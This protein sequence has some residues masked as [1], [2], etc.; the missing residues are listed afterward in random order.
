MINSQEIIERSVY[1]AILRVAVALGYSLDPNEYLPVSEANSVKL[2]EDIAKLSKYIPIFGTANSSS[3][4]QKTTPRI[5]V[6]ARGFYPGSIGLPKELI[7]K[8]EGVGFSSNEEPYETLDQYIDVHLV[9]NNQEDLRL[10]HQILF[11]SLPQ[12]GYIKPYNEENFLPSG[13]IFIEVG[14]FF[15]YPNTTL[16]LLEKVYEYKVYDTLIGEKED[17]PNDLVP[18]SSIEVVLEQY[19]YDPLLIVPESTTQVSQ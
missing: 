18:I 14:N 6:N 13:N 16:G 7:E 2:K 11:W 9:A 12:R 4:D 19:G 1:A 5:V 15:D 8:S 17:T 10:L 3:K